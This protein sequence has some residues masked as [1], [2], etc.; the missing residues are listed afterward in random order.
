MGYI[1][2]APSRYL[3]RGADLCTCRGSNIFKDK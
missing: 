1:N 3:P 2:S